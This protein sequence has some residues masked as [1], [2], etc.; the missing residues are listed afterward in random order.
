MVGMVDVSAEADLG[1]GPEE[2]GG[3][4]L[5]MP[6]TLIVEGEDWSADLAHAAPLPRIGEVVEFITDEGERRRF[7]VRDVIHTVQRSADDRP[8]VRDEHWTPNSTV[9]G[10]DDGPPGQLRA[11]L[12]RVIVSA[13]D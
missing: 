11:G 8:P 5:G 10:E 13:E 6:W 12:P 4:P 2:G 1:I 3:P 7:R 9:D